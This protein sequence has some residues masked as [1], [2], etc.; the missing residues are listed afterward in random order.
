MDHGG[1]FIFSLQCERLAFHYAL[2]LF[3]NSW[4]PAVRPQMISPQGALVD[5]D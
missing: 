5:S 1:D 4:T 3:T 2:V